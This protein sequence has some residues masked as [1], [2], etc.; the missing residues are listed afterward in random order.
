MEFYSIPTGPL[1]PLATVVTVNITKLRFVVTTGPQPWAGTKKATSYWFFPYS[2]LSLFAPDERVDLFTASWAYAGQKA[3][4]LELVKTWHPN[5]TVVRVTIGPIAPNQT[6]MLEVAFTAPTI[7]GLPPDIQKFLRDFNGAYP[8]GIALPTAKDFVDSFGA[9]FIPFFVGGQQ[10][11]LA[12]RSMYVVAQAV[13]VYVTGDNKWVGSPRWITVAGATGEGKGPDISVQLVGAANLQG[14]SGT[15]S[16]NFNEFVNP[17][18]HPTT[19]KSEADAK[20]K[21]HNLLIG[22]SR[23]PYMLWLGF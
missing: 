12:L 4:N 1:L 9:V 18:F 19:I 11:I 10:D 5:Y 13:P 21:G 6:K 7:F 20:D 15:Q 2:K 3:S 23:P 22:N 17:W 8:W 16:A 14:L